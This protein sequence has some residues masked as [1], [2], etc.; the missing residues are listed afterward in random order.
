M[1]GE[2]S[3]SILG[4]LQLLFDIIIPGNTRW[5]KV[6]FFLAEL[7]AIEVS[8]HVNIFAVCTFST[9]CSLI[10]R[11]PHHN[12]IFF[13]FFVREIFCFKGFLG[14]EVSTNL[15][16]GGVGVAWMH[17]FCCEPEIGAKGV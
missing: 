9:S 16:V 10:S 13:P 14:P 17:K 11:Q 4:V 2:E 15:N 7:D 8:R 5:I 1:F 12:Q 3:E 6:A